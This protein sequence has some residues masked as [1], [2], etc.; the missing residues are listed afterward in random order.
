[1]R[2]KE[3]VEDA[4][5]RQGKRRSVW[6]LKSEGL[7][8]GFPDRLLLAPGARFALVETKA[9]GRLLRPGQRIV[10]KWLRRLGIEVTVIDHPDQIVPFYTRWLGE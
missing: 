6:V 3:D 10:R 7:W 5:R 4:L 2:E 9:P 8:P 1:M